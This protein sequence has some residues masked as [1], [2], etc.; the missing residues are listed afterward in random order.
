[1]VYRPDTP[2]PERVRAEERAISRLGWTQLVVIAIGVALLVAFFR[3]GPGPLVV[4][5]ALAALGGATTFTRARSG[6]LD[7]APSVAPAPPPNRLMTVSLY[8]LPGSIIASLIA[9]EWVGAIAHLLS[10]GLGAAIGII[11]AG[12]TRSR[13]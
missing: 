1:M 7:F 10:Y 6:A 13:S 9:G 5:A 4:C 8:V 3:P 2:D 11:L 12:N